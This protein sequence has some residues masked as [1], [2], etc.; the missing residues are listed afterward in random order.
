MAAGRTSIR[1]TAVEGAYRE[2]GRLTEQ[3]EEL[4]SVVEADRA[5]IHKEIRAE[6]EHELDRA[7]ILLGTAWKV[8]VLAAGLVVA[9]FGFWGIKTARDV[10]DGIE[11]AAEKLV[12]GKLGT[13]SPGSPLRR[14]LD[15]ATL[16]SYLIR[17]A[18]KDAAQSNSA[19]LR[20]TV[21][22]DDTTADR[23]LEII[24]AG[25]QAEN[26]DFEDALTV[27]V[28]ARNRSSWPRVRM[29][30]VDVVRAEGTPGLKRDAAARGRVL[31][32][33]RRQ[34]IPELTASS[35]VLLDES[36]P[37]LVL[38]AARYLAAN[39]DVDCV[40]ALEKKW[41]GTNSPDIQKAVVRA[42]ARLKPTS[43]TVTAY[44]SRVEG[45][46]G[47][48]SELAEAATV[49]GMMAQGPPQDRANAFFE[50]QEELD[51]VRLRLARRLLAAAVTKGVQFALDPYGLDDEE[52]LWAFMT[53]GRSTS[54]DPHALLGQGSHV[55]EAVLQDA[56]S[57]NDVR[58]LTRAVKAFSV[59]RRSL[60]EASGEAAAIVSLKASDDAT[61]PVEG[62]R[63]I[64]LTAGAEY[65]LRT[66][67]DGKL[68]ITLPPSDGGDHTVLD[69]R[70][71]KGATFRF[72]ATPGLARLL[73]PED[74]EDI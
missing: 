59:V 25:S 4:K 60:G 46:P 51:P 40:P 10:N 21:A 42:L 41:A 47:S 72:E 61:L 11:A 26:P 31:T 57:T 64:A 29:A 20:S 48:L 49:S 27:L 66:T 19:R 33:M 32:A 30:L 63:Q 36:D 70:G 69:I 2:I 53:A 68:V 45:S 43:S 9:F 18:R 12:A 14:V 15:R 17:L 6:I 73:R 44:V 56:A 24:R 8:L 71:L 5:D 67:P 3:L 28:R 50:E 22:V 62:K 16:D 23:L 34:R 65:R 38:A 37:S 58:A 7:R 1:D 55:V 52:A 13:S 74:D 35:K 39:G 54:V